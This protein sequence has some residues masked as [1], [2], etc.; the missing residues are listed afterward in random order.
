MTDHATP[1]PDL[2]GFVLGGLSAEEEASF[3]NHLER[4]PEC[5]RE[6]GE[7]AAAPQVGLLAGTM[8]RKPQ[9]GDQQYRRRPGQGP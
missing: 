5:R 2:G 3:R 4:C 8:L 7:D 9:T 6:V 1:H